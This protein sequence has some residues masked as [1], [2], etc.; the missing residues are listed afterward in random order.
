M[1]YAINL[2]PQVH[3]MLISNKIKSFIFHDYFPPSLWHLELN[4]MIF[5]DMALKRITYVKSSTCEWDC[6][7][8]EVFS[9]LILEIGVDFCSLASINDLF[10]LRSTG[11]FWV[12]NITVCFYSTSNLFKQSEWTTIKSHSSIIPHHFLYTTNLPWYLLRMCRK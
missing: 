6:M 5:A 12:L 1:I 8:C 9:K 2:T 4:W 7:R 11:Q 3:I 10:G